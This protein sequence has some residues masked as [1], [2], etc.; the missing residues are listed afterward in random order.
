MYD[1]VCDKSKFD[2]KDGNVGWS[3]ELDRWW[4][5]MDACMYHG[6]QFAQVLSINN[7]VAVGFLELNSTV[8]VDALLNRPTGLRP[9]AALGPSPC[10]K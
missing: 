10:V 5:A 7:R 9:R 4:R 3:E 1:C 6:C 2:F 8:R